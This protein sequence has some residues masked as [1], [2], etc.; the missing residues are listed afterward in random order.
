MK[1]KL[2]IIT[3]CFNSESSIART[4]SSVCTQKNSEVEYIIIDGN[5]N[6]KTIEIVNSFED[7]IDKIISEKDKGIYDAYNKGILNSTGEYIM[8]LNSDDWLAESSVNTILECLKS[9]NE[10]Y[11]SSI[12]IFD[13]KQNLLY[14]KKAKRVHI[15]YELFHKNLKLFN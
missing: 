10:I 5:S 7:K 4:L 12:N 11:C 3:I 14:K 2:S 6:D 1:K 13:E 8:F 9:E 15:S